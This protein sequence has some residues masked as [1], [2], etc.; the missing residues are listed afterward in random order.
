[1]GAG[2]SSAQSMVF[3]SV[4]FFFLSVIKQFI[5]PKE[6]YREREV[7]QCQPHGK[8]SW[9]SQ[10][11]LRETCWVDLWEVRIRMRGRGLR[12]GLPL[13]LPLR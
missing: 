6:K 1:M 10:L 5:D 8:D 3:F 11:Q 4:L 13:C 2:P 12:V 9:N 7:R